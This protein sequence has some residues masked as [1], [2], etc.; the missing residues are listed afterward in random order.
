MRYNGK[1]FL[2]NEDEIRFINH[3][4]TALKAA[5]IFLPLSL[6]LKSDDIINYKLGPYQIGRTKLRG[7]CKRIQI[8]TLKD[9]KWLEDITIDRAIKQIPRW[10]N[11]AKN[12]I[13]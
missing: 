12:L 3:L 4:I 1:P 9:V 7:E 6:E 10:I 8:L 11:Y 2:F 5:N 13:D